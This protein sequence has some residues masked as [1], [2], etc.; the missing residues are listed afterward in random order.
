MIGVRGLCG[1]V[2][3]VCG[4][5]LVWGV[6]VGVKID[7]YFFSLEEST[8]VRLGGVRGGL[9]PRANFFEKRVI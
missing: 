8:M 1:L 2:C 7:S 4:G 5:V 3:E 6:I 9:P